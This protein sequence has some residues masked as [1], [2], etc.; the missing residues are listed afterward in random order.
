M[1]HNVNAGNGYRW[2][3]LVLAWFCIFT[4]AILFQ[5]IPPILGMLV[6]SL[7]ITYSQAGGLMSLFT[8]PSIFLSIPG[9]LLVD[10]YG[11]KLV[12]GVSLLT[13]TIGTLIA[14][15]GG[16]YLILAL[17][18]LVAGIG[19]VVV[20]IVTFKIV[21]TW[22]RGRE[23]GL[24]M[25]LFST[26]MPLGT[27]ISLT[28]MGALGL[29]F[30][31]QGPIWL[32][33]AVSVLAFILY[34]ALYR[35]RKIGGPV[36]EMPSNW[37]S[38]MKEAGM[39][40]WYVGSVWALYNA[41]MISYFTYAPDYFVSLGEDVSQAGL[42]ASYTMWGPLILAPFVGMFIDRVGG[43]WLFVVVGCTGVSFLLYAMPYFTDQHVL[44]AILI[45]LFMAMVA[46]SIFALPA[47][48]LPERMTGLGFGIIN[49]MFGVGVFLGPYVVGF[50]RDISGAYYWS[51]TAMSA[52]ALL[53]VIPMLLLKSQLGG[54]KRK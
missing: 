13:T 37:L 11:A 51:F 22:F 3:I 30:G 17:G 54:A 45:G 39:G 40:I 2:I 28:F 21:T 32:G 31:W 7:H 6:N 49:T 36:E 53:G 43:K 25:G 35:A 12:G 23:I 19:A 26:S 44:I 52:F 42:Q 34:L 20:V 29:R 47:E 46:T 1:P 10:R 4:F 38:G 33:L 15:L 48:L 16:S 41:A 27:I 8:L 14:A 50:S 9:G 5:S 18:R 24:S